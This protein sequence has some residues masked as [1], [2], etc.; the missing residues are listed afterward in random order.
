M[1]T[2]DAHYGALFDQAQPTPTPTHEPGPERVI[3]TVP[4]TT[5]LLDNP[6][7]FLFVLVGAAVLLLRFSVRGSF[8]VGG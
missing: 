7:L 3:R 6:L 1:F 8:E 5:G 2:A 4:L